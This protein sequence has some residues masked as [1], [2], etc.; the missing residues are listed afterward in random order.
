[1]KS[2]V[3]KR[4]IVINSHKTSISLEDEFWAALKVIAAEQQLT[5]SEL[6]G[7]IDERR[8]NGNLSSAVRLFVLNCYQ[9]PSYRVAPFV[10]RDSSPMT[11]VSGLAD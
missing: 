9:S 4:S 11:H 6:V 10:R 2:L 1:M 3:V 7:S 5:L 8:L